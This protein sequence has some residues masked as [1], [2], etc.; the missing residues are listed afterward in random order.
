[1][2]IAV[3]G[4]S[5]PGSVSNVSGSECNSP[6]ITLDQVKLGLVISESGGSGALTS[7]RSGIDARLSEA[8]AAG[9]VHG[10]RISYS[11]RDDHSSVAED[12]RATE[13]LVHRDS[14]FGLLAATSSLGGSLDSLV[15]EQVPVVG[16][17]ADANWV[18]QSNFFSYMY[19]G[20]V[21]VLAG[22]IRSAGGTKVAVV[23]P[24]AS[25]FTAGAA[26][27]VGDEMSLN[28]LTYVGSFPYSR[29]AD[30]PEQV[31]RNIA[32]SGANALVALT[33]P[34]DL[35]ALM[36]A[37]R[38]AVPNLAV[39]VAMSGYDRSILP[40]FGRA[41]AGVS[42][43]VYFR[44]FEAGG[45]AIERYRQSMATFAPQAPFPEQQF[46]MNAYIYADIF[47]RGLELAGPC[48][49]REGFINALRGVDNYDAGGLIAPV[50]LADNLAQPPMCH[51]IVQVSPAGDAF[52]VVRE[53]I[54]ADG[55]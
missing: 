16:L 15:A 51:S 48:P 47:L 39:T 52:Q 28:G 17:A 42:I 29:G 14:V 49:T 33:I 4:C 35:A 1:M 9:G 22:Y 11:W 44:P 54:C 23:T 46:A 10:R 45:P 25:P 21:P 32:A 3:V 12:A 6:G 55:S 30:S 50:D 8:N 13:D 37:L 24:G 7:A 26:K 34:E 53:R 2:T 41:L 38:A 19:Q 18:K 40:A 36:Q 31:A 20:S 5:P 27:T 43:P